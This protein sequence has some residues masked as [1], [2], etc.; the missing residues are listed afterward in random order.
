MLRT[1]HSLCVNKLSFHARWHSLHGCG[2]LGGR[3]NLAMS[4]TLTTKEERPW[5]FSLT[6]EL[7]QIMWVS[8]KRSFPSVIVFLAQ[9]TVVLPSC[10]VAQARDSLPTSSRL[11]HHRIKQHLDFSWGECGGGGIKV[12][13]RLL[14]PVPCISLYPFPSYSMKNIWY[15]DG[16]H[17]KQNSE[18][19]GGDRPPTPRYCQ[20]SCGFSGL[21]LSS[22]FMS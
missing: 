11:R 8:R 6:W 18:V 14:M 15:K 2:V 21:C 9:N 10:A 12:H 20:R 7:V 5:C 17:L 3:E 22:Y 13:L 16:F 1:P 19:G 4:E